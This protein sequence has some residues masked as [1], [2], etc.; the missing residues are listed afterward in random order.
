MSL[1]VVCPAPRGEWERLIDADPLAL[2]YQTPQWLSAIC[3]SSKY[4]DASR[5][6]RLDSG[7][8]A[9]VPLVRRSGLPRGLSPAASLPEGWGIGGVVSDGNLNASDLTAILVD[10]A[11]LPYLYTRIRP[12]PLRSALW[13]MAQVGAQFSRTRRRVHILDLTGGFDTVWEQRFSK[14]TRSGVRRAINAGVE[15]ELDNAGNLVDTF[16]DVLE[17]SVRRWADQQHEPLALAMTRFR[18]RDPRSKFKAIA[19]SMGARC[20]IWVARH[21]GQAVAASLRLV[22]EGGAANASRS[23]MIKQLAAPVRANDLLLMRAIEDACS[24]GCRYFVLGES[25]GSRGIARYKERFGAVA[26]DYWE[27][28]LDPWRLKQ[29]DQL[30]RKA[31]KATIGFVDHN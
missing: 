7:Q 28:H 1:P 27:Y 17:Q 12:N 2:P 6:Y 8:Q 29:G 4:S 15:V 20:R 5:M 19:D 11:Q 30:A 31:V 21:Q 9:V 24:S 26:H 16:Y 18:L 13:D 25:G 14:A 10:L 22:K 3:A 23:A